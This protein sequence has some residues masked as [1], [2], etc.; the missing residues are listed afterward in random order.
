M[1]KVSS[2]FKIIEKVFPYQLA[3]VE[4]TPDHGPDCISLDA[5]FEPTAEAIY[6]LPTDYN[7]AELLIHISGESEDELVFHIEL[8]PF[9][10]GLRE[11]LME[12]M[13]DIYG[14]L[15]Y[16]VEY[17]SP[18]WWHD[19]DKG[20]DFLNAH[21]RKGLRDLKRDVEDESRAY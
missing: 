11:C 12:A 7:Y 5:I 3:Y 18:L 14:C 8:G 15:D 9:D 20:Y 19:R 17:V 21:V 16:H 13:G 1:D 6:K 10:S 2:I 4:T